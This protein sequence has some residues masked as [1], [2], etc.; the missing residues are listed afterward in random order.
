MQKKK[1]R[2]KRFLL[3]ACSILIVLGIAGIFAVN[4]AI[5]K[6]IES[7]A[8]SMFEEIESEVAG[9]AVPTIVPTPAPTPAPTQGATQP[10][11]DEPSGEVEQ[12]SEETAGKP[13]APSN[14]PSTQY[15]E[16]RGKS[17]ANLGEYTAEVTT[18]KAN[19][20]KE[21]VTVSE[22]A[23]VASILMGNLSF[24]DLK[25][26][27]ELAGGGMTVDE[28]RVARKILLDK[29]TPEEYEIL[30][31]IA[32]KY[33]ISRGLTYDEAQQEEANASK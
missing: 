19:A 4:Y 13:T 20:I 8:N 26:L 22:K 30:S 10:T 25:L 23:D 29:L 27:Q 7:M 12:S 9:Q 17:S 15:N 5:D 16:D 31:T 6:V 3:W 24:S 14:K 1:F 33:G 18:E 11:A 2:W 21:N 28:K 32:K